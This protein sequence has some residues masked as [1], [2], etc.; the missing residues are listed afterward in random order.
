[1]FEGCWVDYCFNDKFTL[2]V[3]SG[4]V[5]TVVHKWTV[6]LLAIENDYSRTKM[7]HRWLLRIGVFLARLLCKQCHSQRH[8]GGGSLFL[9]RS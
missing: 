6:V 3:N 7:H 9:F 8:D 1:M 4:I 2:V 5:F